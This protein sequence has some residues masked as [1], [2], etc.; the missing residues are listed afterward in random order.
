MLD[1][2]SEIF[3][4][5]AND[6]LDKL[7]DLLL[8]L[9]NNKED[10]ETIQAIFRAM[11]TIKG[12]AGMFG[13]DEISRFT[14]EVETAFDGVRN[15]RIVVT[16]D[17]V[18]ITLAARDHI[19]NMLEDSESTEILVESERIKALL[20]EYV[21][22]QTLIG[23]Q[24]DEK[25]LAEVE[26]QNTV[27]KD[28]KSQNIVNVFENEKEKTYRIRFEPSQSIFLNGTRIDNLLAEL[29]QLG[30]ITVHMNTTGIPKLSQINTDFC[31]V[32]FDIYLSTQEDM[33]AIEDVF[34]FLDD[35]SLVQITSLFELDEDDDV[36]VKRLGE[37]LVER[38]NISEKEITQA[39][40]QQKSIGEIL[41]EKNVVSKEA[42][43]AALSEQEHMKKLQ[44]NKQNSLN[45]QT[46]KVNS[47]KLDR[48]IDLVGELVTFDA[49]LNQLSSLLNNSNLTSLGEQ[50]ERLIIE[51]RD[52]TMD[53]RM[54]PI[55]TLF[56]RFHRL[57]RDLSSEMNKNIV[58]QAEGAETELDKTVIEKL[59][60]PLVHLIRNAVDHGI[61]KPEK[62]AAL[63]KNEQGTVILRA[64]HAG[65][66]VLITIEDDGKGMD[67]D[68]LYAKALE[69]GIVKPEDNLS[70][71]E[72]YE[73]IFAP[74]FSTAEKVTSVSGRG[75]GMDVVKKDITALGGTVTVQTTP[76]KGTK[77]VLKL[78]L[79][80]AIIEG[81]L[82]KIGE[83]SYVIPLSNVV[84]CLEFQRPKVRKLCSSVNIRNEVI[85][86]IDLR[87][88]FAVED[89][90]PQTE[91]III[92]T[93]QDSKIG[94][95]IDKVIGNF[96]TVIKPLGRLY[97]NVTGISGATI[98]GDGSVALILDVYKLSTVIQELDMKNKKTDF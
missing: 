29:S 85:P 7:E 16:S 42:V 57:V 6:L 28:K 61:E 95:I 11:H 30:K 27:E 67:K 46:I 55:G 54:V 15:G 73:L 87:T 94:L 56:S 48:L 63:G 40:G 69:K 22:T 93:D 35:K 1:N 38:E 77:F 60:D 32:S 62:R 8:T 19:R 21:K 74:G 25:S 33:N 51:L 71:Q 76:G 91:H 92:V 2:M 9:E 98:L 13:F 39:L 59:N 78:P 96:Q 45:S 20:K 34:I 53:M 52:T 72:I 3:L 18:S 65:A 66:F 14:H 81:I 82:V 36:P 80:L 97:K 17:L 43:T 86:Y 5:E 23:S 89:E 64:Q 12:S 83:N 47:E 88:F 75:V 58:L 84:E 49:R 31:Y 26:T 70:E 4:E 68:T 41:V 79:T 50:G 10:Q 24:D 37:I 90:V 44:Q